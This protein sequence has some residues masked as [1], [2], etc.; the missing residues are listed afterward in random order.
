MHGWLRPVSVLGGGFGGVVI[1]TLGLAGVLVP[2]RAA[3]FP[4]TP[5]LGPVADI[6]ERGLDPTSGVPG[7]GGTIT[8]TGD[9]EGSFRITREVHQGAY[10]IEGEGNRITFSGEPVRVSQVSYDGLEF[11]PDDDQCS[12]TT[13]NLEGA[14]GIGFADL[15]C[16]DLEDVRGGAKVSLSGEIGLPLNRLVGRQ[17]PKSGGTATVGDE[18]WTFEEASLLTWQQ[19]ARGGVSDYNLVLE[20]RGGPPRALAFA[21]DIETHALSLANVR[22]GNTDADVPDGACRFDRHEL[23]PHN[24]RI[25]VVELTITCPSVDVPGMGVVAIS[26]SA[27][28]DEIGWPE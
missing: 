5:S 6:N 9:R 24:P 28:V 18:T 15:R 11:F 2:D 27:V 22:V 1:V 8:V 21:Y 23:G 14:I 3:S 16:D 10:A 13:G 7:L 20:D 4:A 25:L 12:L 17:L 19:P 26:G